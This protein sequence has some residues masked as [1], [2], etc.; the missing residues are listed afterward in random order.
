M[1]TQI[2]VPQTGQLPKVK[3]PEFNDRDRINDILSYEKYLTAGYNTGL[4]EMQNPKLREAI[5]SI[6]R[7][8]HDNQFQ[9][10]DLM[11]QKGW[12]KMK[13]ADKQEI[14][15]AHQQFSNYKTQFPTFS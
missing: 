14:G 8:V 12:Y 6:L 3:G 1:A 10:F 4:N 5:G 9:L 2:A 13:A 7:D 11:F 15:Q